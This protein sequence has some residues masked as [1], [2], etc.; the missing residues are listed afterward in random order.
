LGCK[1]LDADRTDS[2]MSLMTGSGIRVL[3]FWVARIWMQT[4]LAQ[5]CL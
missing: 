3:N 4:E 5:N 2:E 1:N